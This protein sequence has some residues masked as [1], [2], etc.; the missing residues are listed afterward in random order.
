[1]IG[2][3]LNEPARPYCEALMGRGILCKETH[4]SVIRLAPPL[5]ATK[6]ELEWALDH[7]QQVLA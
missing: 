6:E 7:L 5:V 3:E 1:M 2:I 4:D